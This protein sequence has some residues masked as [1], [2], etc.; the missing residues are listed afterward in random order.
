VRLR[1]S[2]AGEVVLAGCV[3]G[4]TAVLVQ[5]SPPGATGFMQKLAYKADFAEV[6][7]KP[8]RAGT[9]AIVVRFQD[10][11]GLPFDP[12]EV[13][14]EIG[15]QAAGVEPANRPIRRVGPGH[16]SRDGSELAFPGL[17][18]I[19]VHARMNASEVATFRSEVPIR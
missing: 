16:Y 6:S 15:N 12:E 14:V 13:L 1:W 18:T 7:V 5:T 8:A 10:K 9:N 19:E 11:E 2:I 4:V 3:I 17:W